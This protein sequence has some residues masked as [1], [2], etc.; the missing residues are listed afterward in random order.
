M[1]SDL[2][3]REPV[4]GVD[5]KHTLDETGETVRQREISTVI[6]CAQRG[7]AG[8]RSLEEGAIAAI[9]PTGLI[10]GEAPRGGRKEADAERPDIRAEAIFRQ[11]NQDFRRA[12]SL[13][14]RERHRLTLPTAILV[15]GPVRDGQAKVEPLG[16]SLLGQDEVLQLEVHVCET[17]TVHMLHACQHLPKD[18]AGANV[19][20][21]SVTLDNLQHLHALCQLEYDVLAARRARLVANNVFVVLVHLQAVESPCLSTPGVHVLERFDHCAFAGD[22][23]LGLEH[24]ALRAAPEG[25]GGRFDVVVHVRSPPPQRSRSVTAEDRHCTEME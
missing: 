24:S 5:N 16:D 22:S 8:V 19:I 14:S 4:L 25:C 21:A 11:A 10:E 20:D 18:A 23:V 3:E 15:L 6:E 9:G 13:G 1:G 2:I 7:R 12:I 17:G